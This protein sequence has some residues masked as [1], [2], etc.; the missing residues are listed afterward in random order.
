MISTRLEFF[1]SSSE[2][3]NPRSM[4]PFS[5][6]NSSSDMLLIR[7]GVPFSAPSLLDPLILLFCFLDTAMGTG[8]AIIFSGIFLDGSEL[9]GDDGFS[10]LKRRIKDS[11]S[12]IEADFELKSVESSAMS[13]LLVDEELK[14][15]KDTH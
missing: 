10:E 2:N 12:I 9:E 13:W 1:A 11:G 3:S 14:H 15:E 5:S 8:I 6:S 7:C 4:N